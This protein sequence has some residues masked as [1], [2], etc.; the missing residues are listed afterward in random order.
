MITIEYRIVEKMEVK[1][2]VIYEAQYK[3]SVSN[4]DN[5]GFFNKML[6]KMSEY[7]MDTYYI[8]TDWKQL[9][10]SKEY[11]GDEGNFSFKRCKQEIDIDKAKR[12]YENK[13]SKIIE[14]IVHEDK[15]ILE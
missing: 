4:V 9:P 6:R 15:L 3:E 10:F 1:G 14:K 7:G 13:Q 8:G 11:V 12:K 5:F 2:S